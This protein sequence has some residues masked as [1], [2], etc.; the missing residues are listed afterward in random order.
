MKKLFWHEL[1]AASTVTSLEG[2]G[3]ITL[4]CDWPSDHW[5]VLAEF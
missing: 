1:W 2:N 3:E 4:D 5:A